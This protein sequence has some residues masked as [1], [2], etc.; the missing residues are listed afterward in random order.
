MRNYLVTD[1]QTDWSGTSVLI[2]ES[3][4][5]SY[6]SESNNLSLFQ[7]SL[8]YFKAH[9]FE[10]APVFVYCATK[11]VLRTLLVPLS[12]TKPTASVKVSLSINTALF[13]TYRLNL[14][15]GHAIGGNSE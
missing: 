15:W 3:L 10:N 7:N 8:I 14:L 1:G 13:L 12:G 4:L 6:K 9:S 2:I 11:P 5:K